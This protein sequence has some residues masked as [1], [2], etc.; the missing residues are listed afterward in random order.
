MELDK[1]ASS[2]YNTV[3]SC[4]TPPK[5]K[6]KMIHKPTKNFK[7][8]KTAKRLVAASKGDAHAR[9]SLRR[10]LI[11]AEISASIVPA[12]K[13]RKAEGAPAKE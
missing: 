11:Q 8:S 5:R 12:K 4:S 13:D 3:L 6:L 2:I 1:V 10:A 7:L 9:G